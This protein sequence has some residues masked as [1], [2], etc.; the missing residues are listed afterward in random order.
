MKILILYLDI[1]LEKGSTSDENNC[2]CISLS[3]LFSS[4]LSH[5]VQLWQSSQ[6]PQLELECRAEDVEVG[7]GGVRVHV[8]YVFGGKGRIPR[9]FEWT[10]SKLLLL[11]I[12]W[13]ICQY[14]YVQLYRVSFNFKLVERK[15]ALN[16]FPVLQL[17]DAGRH[18]RADD[19]AERRPLVSLEVRRSEV[20]PVDRREVSPMVERFHCNEG[21]RVLNL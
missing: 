15:T 3:I 20:E 13:K 18:P 14:Q 11:R 10:L 2:H 21:C 17:P 5:L 6:V 16:S 9:R 7:A 19:V 8:D 4:L 1:C 12:C